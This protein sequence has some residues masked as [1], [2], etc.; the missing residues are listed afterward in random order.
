MITTTTTAMEG[1]RATT[2]VESGATSKRKL[3]SAFMSAGDTV[4]TFEGGALSGVGSRHAGGAAPDFHVVPLV[5]I[6]RWNPSADMHSTSSNAYLIDASFF[7]DNT[8]CR[9]T[10]SCCYPTS[11][12]P[13]KL[14]ES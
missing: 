6:K 12:F 11:S 4:N 5:V 14:L 9:N 13:M 3:Q 2:G 7:C 1:R 10:S 8:D